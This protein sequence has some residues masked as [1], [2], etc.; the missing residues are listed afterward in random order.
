MVKNRTLWIS[1]ALESKCLKICLQNNDLRR[2][3]LHLNIVI[4]DCLAIRDELRSHKNLLHVL[5]YKDC[6]PFQFLN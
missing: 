5:F 3:L 2:T 6:N 1:R 4:E